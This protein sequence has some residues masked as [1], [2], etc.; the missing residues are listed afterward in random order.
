MRTVHFLNLQ[1]LALYGT[2]QASAILLTNSI[3][4][5][6]VK[7][8]KALTAKTV[9]DTGFSIRTGDAYSRL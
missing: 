2:E 9:L 4:S 1:L 5:L 7:D 8:S 3:L 6:R